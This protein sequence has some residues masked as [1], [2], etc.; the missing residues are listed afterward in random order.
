M[1]TIYLPGTYPD[2]IKQVILS[3]GQVGV[4]LANRWML[5]WPAE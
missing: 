3:E 2:Q 4:E 5:G 1:Q